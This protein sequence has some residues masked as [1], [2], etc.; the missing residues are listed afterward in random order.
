MK[1]KSYGIC[2][3]YIKDRKI[4]ILINKTSEVSY[5]NFFKGK[6]EGSETKEECS[7]R[8]LCEEARYDF[9]DYKLDDY[10]EQKN[11]RKDV[12]IFLIQIDKPVDIYIDRKEIYSYEWKE[13]TSDIIFSRNQQKIYNKIFLFLKPLRNYL[14]F[15]AITRK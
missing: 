13:L 7:I 5:W 6:I 8:E 2:P 15:T 11:R 12:G 1:E 3:F 9:S 14:K 4:F 10:F